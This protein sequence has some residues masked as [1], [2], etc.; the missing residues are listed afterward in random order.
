M[1]VSPYP[2]AW[3]KREEDDKCSVASNMEEEEHIVIE[4]DIQK[5]EDDGTNRKE[6]AAEKPQEH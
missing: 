5:E 6:K 2:M 1:H 4:A 3:I